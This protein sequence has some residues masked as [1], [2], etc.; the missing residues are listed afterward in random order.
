M[1]CNVEVPLFVVPVPVPGMLPPG[2]WV[3]PLPGVVPPVPECVFVGLSEL[4]VKLPPRMLETLRERLRPRE[5]AAFGYCR[6]FIVYS[7]RI[8]RT[9]NEYGKKSR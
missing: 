3:L 7:R 2:V 5:T 4:P 8:D 9:E 1:S 6:F